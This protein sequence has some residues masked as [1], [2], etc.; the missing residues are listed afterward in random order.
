MKLLLGLALGY[1]GFL[2]TQTLTLVTPVLASSDNMATASPQKARFNPPPPPKDPAPGGRVLGGAT[3]GSCPKVQQDLTAL[4]PFT[5]EP[6]SITNVWSLTTAA[7]P[8]FWF[9]IPYSQKDTI[10]A[11][12]I[13]Q[14]QELNQV[15]QQAIALPNQPGI[16]SVSLPSDAPVLD[17][18][19]RYR[20]FL[21]FSCGKEGQAPLVYV[22]GVI[23]RVTL[24]PEITKQ[25][26]TATPLQKFAIYAENGIWHEALTTLAKLRQKNPQDTE[27]ETQWQDLLISIRLGDVATEPVLLDKP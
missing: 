12:F 15:Y 25:L 17:V 8:T 7:H 13:L 2:A 5:Q 27:L 26:Q 11:K 6:P 9:Y 20:W 1:A 18:G 24:S 23:K 4:V 21:I 22:E 19:K 3:R 16:M 14:D 10:P